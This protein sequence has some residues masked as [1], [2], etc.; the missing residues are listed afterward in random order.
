[1]LLAQ[2][3]VNARVVAAGLLHDTLDDSFVDY[4]YISQRF[5]AG[6]ADLVEGVYPYI[7]SIF[8]YSMQ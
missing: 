5:G 8:H 2:I 6:V 4:D 7:F 3:G 1:M